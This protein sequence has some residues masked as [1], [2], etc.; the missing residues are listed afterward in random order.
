MAEQLDAGLEISPEWLVFDRELG[1]GEFGVVKHALATRIHGTERVVPV[2]VKVL[3][4]SA[5]DRDKDAFVREG[6]R[7]KDLHHENIVRL[8]GACMHRE[9]RMLVL[10][11]MSNGDLK[12][13][14]QWC[15]RSGSTLSLPHLMRIGVDV[16]RGFA[17]LQS[18]KF[19]HRDLA[20]RNVL[21]D[22]GFRAKIGDFGLHFC[23]CFMTC[24][25]NASER[26]GAENV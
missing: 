15:V 9:P 13:Y 22:A 14:L 23:L 3:R 18:M 2:A 8:L 12:L 26:N 21:L 10:E 1:Q 4:D 17:Y 25:F 16:A 5:T 11:Y 19:V 24:L 6:L 20:A 7:L